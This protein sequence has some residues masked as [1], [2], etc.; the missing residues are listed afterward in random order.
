[1]SEQGT[2]EWFQNRLGKVTASRV[3]DVMAKT[4]SG[5]AASRENYMAQLI[6]EILTGHREESFTN[7]A[8]AWGV[9][10]EPFARAAYESKKDVLV[11]EV[12]FVPHPKIEG[13]GA[14][15]DGLVGDIGLIEIKCPNTNTAI[16]AWIKFAEGKNPVAGKYNAQMQMQMAC[17]GRNWCDYIIYDPRMPENAQLF[18]VRVDRDDDFIAEMESEIKKFIEEMNEKILKLNNAVRIV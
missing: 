18:M 8:M 11:D 5:Y 17:T 4:K 14:S 1:M 16:D 15:P 6:C 9:E 13:A 3:A 2:P 7:A 10:Q 12:G